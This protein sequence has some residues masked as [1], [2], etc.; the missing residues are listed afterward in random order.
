MEYL[1]Q[2]VLNALS[3]G[4]NYALLA[5]GLAIVFSV[6]GLVNFAY[7]EVIA[8][9]GYVM[10]AVFMVSGI[11]YA[12]LL[13]PVGVLAAIGISVALERVAF[14]PVRYAPAATGLLTAFGVSI[15]I[16]NFFVTLVATRS[17]A[18]PT[19][20][21]LGYQIDIGIA[22]IQVIQILETSVTALALLLLVF[23][24]RRTNIG[25]AMRAAARDF[26]MVRMVGINANKVIAAAFAVSGFLA[27]LAAIFIIA[28][29]GVVDPFMGFTPVLKA[30]VAAVLG[31]FGSLP[32]AVVGGFLLGA[33]EVFFQI[34]L[35]SS[36]A[37]YRDAFVFVLVSVIL[38]WRPQ[39]LVG[40]KRQFGDKDE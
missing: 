30:F 21:W 31:G 22:R 25:L 1:V 2:Q 20:Q 36:I 34:V 32:G 37:G 11:E 16:R 38:V 24:L 8:V 29:R 10:F 4:G 33:L 27:G 7:G 35:P 9:A 28:R 19:P 18:V 39:G 40:T 15:V 23:I 13:M 3:I 6:I 26:D 12:V 14:R 5:L 17:K